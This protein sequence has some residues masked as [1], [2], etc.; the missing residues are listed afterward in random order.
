[1]KSRVEKG[2]S[3]EIPEVR[4]EH[5]ALRSQGEGH[6]QIFLWWRRVQEG[7]SGTGGVVEWETVRYME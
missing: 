2:D 1:M 3:S 4:F 6:S 7:E 5:W